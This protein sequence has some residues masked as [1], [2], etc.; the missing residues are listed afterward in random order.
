MNPYIELMY[1]FAA[2]VTIPRFMNPPID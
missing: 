2:T 1:G